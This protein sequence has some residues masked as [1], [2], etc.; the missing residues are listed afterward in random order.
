MICWLWDKE[1]GG[2]VGDCRC[3][4]GLF[5]SKF[6]TAVF[7][8]IRCQQSKML[9]VK[10]CCCKARSL[11]GNAHCSPAGMC[12]TDTVWQTDR[13]TFRA[14]NG[15]SLPSM[16]RSSGMGRGR[17]WRSRG[18][19]GPPWSHPCPEVPDLQWQKCPVQRHCP[20]LRKGH[21]PFLLDYPMLPVIPEII[22][23]RNQQVHSPA[24]FTGP[25]TNQL[26]KSVFH[27]P[28]HGHLSLVISC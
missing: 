7:S 14:R 16:G 8:L 2:T 19:K 12:H 24:L 23:V 9:G 21:S 28:G 3:G 10:C 26:R 17:G 27:D 20:T 5:N 6:H 25:L 22:S 4:L 13:Q 11:S 18:V 15:S 1:W